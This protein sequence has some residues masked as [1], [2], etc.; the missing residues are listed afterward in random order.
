METTEILLDKYSQ[1][2]VNYRNDVAKYINYLLF[3]AR[4][5]KNRKEIKT[6]TYESEI[7]DLAIERMEQSKLNPERRLKWE[8]VKKELYQNKS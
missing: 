2:P 5:I 8:E 4:K 6:N 3:K 1:L 7:E